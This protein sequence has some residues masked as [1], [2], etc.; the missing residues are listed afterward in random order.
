MRKRPFTCGDTLAAGLIA[1]IRNAT[2]A[3]VSASL[4]QSVI[5]RMLTGLFPGV[6]DL[7]SLN[8]LRTR[9]PGAL[10]TTL[11]YK[12][13]VG[14]SRDNRFPGEMHKLRVRPCGSVK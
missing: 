9:L 3:E 8:N 13:S 4:G 10:V 11:E 2:Y 1:E 7:L 6:S 5:N 14:I 12:P